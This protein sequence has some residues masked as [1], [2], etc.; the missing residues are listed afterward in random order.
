MRRRFFL[1]ATSLGTF[2]LWSGLA[3]ADG[4]STLNLLMPKRL[5][6]VKIDISNLSNPADKRIPLHLTIIHKVTLTDLA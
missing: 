2:G 5:R 1:E 3:I 4:K 6:R